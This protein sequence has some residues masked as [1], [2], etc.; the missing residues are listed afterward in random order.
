LGRVFEVDD[1]RCPADRMETEMGVHVYRDARQAHLLLN[2]M[3]SHFDGDLYLGTLL[4]NGILHGDCVLYQCPQV[5]EEAVG[6]LD[7]NDLPP[8]HHLA[9]GVGLLS[10]LLVPRVPLGYYPH[11]KQQNILLH[12]FVLR[13]LLTLL[14]PGFVTRTKQ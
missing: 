14:Q 4:V 1:W 12:S 6:D 13:C 5:R 9:N 11:L 3:A 8:P 2:R 7:D 10:L